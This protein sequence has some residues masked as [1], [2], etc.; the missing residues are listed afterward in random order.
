MTSHLT[1]PARIDELF[2]AH[3]MEVVKPGGH[4]IRRVTV[5]PDLEVSREL[6]AV[7]K[8]S[9]TPLREILIPVWS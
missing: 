6:D 2:M 4:H 9:L 1:D 7:L 3:V 8:V 5:T